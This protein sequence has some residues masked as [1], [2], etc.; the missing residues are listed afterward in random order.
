MCGIVGFISKTVTDPQQVIRAMS[1][2]LVHRGPDDVGYCLDRQT[3]LALG[4]RRLSILDLSPQGHQPMN[5]HC[6]RYTVVFNGEIYNF[7]EIRNRLDHEG[8]AAGNLWRGHSDTEVLLAAVSAWKVTR[9]LEALVGMFAFALWDRQDRVLHLA[10]DRFG[11]KPLYYGVFG[12]TVVFGSELKA[13]V[14]FPGLSLEIDRNALSMLMQYGYIPSP[15]S[16]YSGIH[17]L[18]PGTTLSV[19]VGLDSQP[20]VRESQSYW[21]IDRIDLPK[22]RTEYAARDDKSLIDELH[23]LIKDSVRQQMVA[24]VPLGAF[25]SGGVDS[26]AVVS[27]M[28]AQSSRPV[29]TFTIGFDDESYNEAR[30]AKA[31]AAHLG[32]DHTELYVTGKDASSVIPRLP[33]IYDE[34]FADSSQIPT[35]LIADLTRKHVTVSLSGDG[36]D[37]LFGGYPR[38]SLG[39]ELWRRVKCLPRFARLS[40]A[41]ILN[42]FSPE[43]W[44][45]FLRLAIPV[46]LRSTLSGHRLH[47]FSRLLDVS[48]FDTM[49][50]YLV[51]QWQAE[52]G[53]V[54]GASVGKSARR[55][56]QAG[57]TE[58]SY[59]NR[60]RRFDLRHYLPDDILTKVDRAT[61][62]VSLESRAPFLDYRLADF[63]WALPERVLSR[64]GESKWIL[65]Q[66]LDR[67][68]P[69]PLIERPKAGFSIPLANWLRTE[70]RDWAED[71]LDN[72]RL[73]DQGYLNTKLVRQTWSEHLSGSHDRQAYLWNIL[74]F[75][76]W[77]SRTQ[78]TWSKQIASG[79]EVVGNSYG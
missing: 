58:E 22:R 15:C 62:A 35:F 36:G 40:T 75:Q 16:I 79:T 9:A 77:L 25:L 38:Y 37:E 46:R 41:H 57:S 24:D 61:M 50:S 66:V 6:G 59:F 30:Y 4:H 31:V 21:S 3:G 60:M 76:A 33:E 12:S 49:Y 32:T 48:D 17:K 43:S 72:R 74:M 5:S 20:R 29:R 26:S 52:D 68:V 45:R 55:F 63:A 47:R 2:T 28:Q 64:N 44:D 69:R 65:R 11:E 27:L 8:Q 73:L 18:E 34:P 19:Q 54:L 71:L 1:D 39:D 51:S 67:Y 42:A 7:E 23:A 14:A 56:G 13:L 78:P 10:R 70:L 53:V